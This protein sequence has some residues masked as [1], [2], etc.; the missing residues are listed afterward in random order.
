MGRRAD[1]TGEPG[2]MEAEA[3]PEALDLLRYNAATFIKALA[4]RGRTA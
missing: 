2:A 3:L 4:I 1:G